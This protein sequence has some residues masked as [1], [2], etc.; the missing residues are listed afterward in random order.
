MTAS[1]IVIQQDRPLT[2]AIALMEEHNVRH[3][4]VLEGQAPIGI[5]SERDVAMAGSLVPDAWEL[6]PVA[7]AMTPNPY[8]VS[9]GTQI[10]EV[11]RAM[12]DHQYGA[13]LVTDEAGALIGVFTSTD[14]M[15]VLA[16]CGAD[17]GT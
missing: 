15:G 7:E 5:L 6:I 4:P 11:A 2:E 14:A 8:A 3:L 13:V 16:A 1:P 10:V 17:D 9:A 12:A